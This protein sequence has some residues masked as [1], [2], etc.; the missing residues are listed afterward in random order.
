MALDR[1]RWDIVGLALTAGYIVGMQV[2]KVPPALPMLQ[3]ELAVPRVSAGLV[4]SSFYGIG[5]VF[6]VLGGL[7]A[8]RLGPVRLVVAGGV[9]MAMAGRVGGIAGDGAL[10]LATRIVEGFGFLALTVS[11]PKLISAAT[12]PDVRSFALGLWGTYMPVGMALSMV[13]ATL[14][15][16]TIGWRGLWFVNAGLIV[17]FVFAFVWGASPRRW[18]MPDPKAGTF[19]EGGVRATLARPGPWLFGACFVL[20]SIQWLALMTWLPTFLI[21]TQGRTLAGAALVSALVVFTTAIGAA[22]GAWFMHRRV[23]RW[24]LIGVAYVA[25]GVC[26]A[27]IF[28]P[29][30]PPPS[31]CRSPSPSPWREAWCPPAVSPAPPRTHPARRGSRWRADSWCRAPHSAACSVPRCLPR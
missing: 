5:A 1:T 25:M 6:G 2:G 16:D 18:R 24:L 20:F 13:L 14:L 17:L 27:L 30:T 29:L 12:R 19:D 9:V 22:G 21:E 11:A 3:E 10:L 4:A 15:L 31:N 23:V 7:L 8:D 28:A 26:S